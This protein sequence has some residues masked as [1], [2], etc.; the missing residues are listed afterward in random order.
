ML[1]DAAGAGD[2]TNPSLPPKIVQGVESKER[3]IDQHTCAAGPCSKKDARG[4]RR[5]VRKT[6]CFTWLRDRA[7]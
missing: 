4:G 1:T 5:A 7:G 6:H 2:T 3:D